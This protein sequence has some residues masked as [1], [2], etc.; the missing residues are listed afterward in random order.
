MIVLFRLLT[1][2]L[3]LLT[4][5]PA[6]AQKADEMA[7][8]LMKKGDALALRRLLVVNRD[9]LNKRTLA[10]AEAY[11]RGC[12]GD[13][14]RAAKDMRRAMKKQNGEIDSALEERLTFGIALQ[15]HRAGKN[16]KAAKTLANYMRTRGTFAMLSTFQQYE[17][18]FRAYHS[19]HIDRVSPGDARIPFRLDSVGGNGVRSVAMRIPA[20]VNGVNAD[21]M[22]DTGATLN[23]VSQ[24]MADSLGLERLGLPVFLD[25]MG[26][27]RGQMALAKSISLGG[28]TL[29]NALFCVMDGQ[30]TDASATE[31]MAHLNAIFGLPLLMLFTDVQIDFRNQTIL[32]TVNADN[33]NLQRNGESEQTFLERGNLSIGFSENGLLLE[34]FHH[35]RPLSLI[36]DTGATHSVLNTADAPEQ[37]DYI[38]SNFPHREVEFVGW[39]GRQRGR[40]YLYPQY[41]VTVGQT[42]VSL[43]EMSVFDA[44][45]YDSRL[46][47]DFFTRC[48]RVSFH[49]R[50]PF[51]LTVIR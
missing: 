3:L 6:F 2:L 34:V 50:Y 51:Q 13:A 37:R 30:Q 44:P 40:E 26:K 39:G 9:S 25:G 22:L 41:D 17:Q 35:G 11:V 7:V 28:R 15:Q 19:Q 47:M 48:E 46:G 24:A 16:R 20:E 14:H 45:V 27:N 12:Q 5:A 33:D 43:P 36:P 18:L 10:L 42:V 1:T 4:F 23:V 38:T 31:N 32:A 29:K 21:F 8:L 49:L